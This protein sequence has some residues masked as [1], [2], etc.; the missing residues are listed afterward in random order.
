MRMTFDRAIARVAERT[1]KN[2]E[3]VKESTLQRRDQ[4]VDLYGIPFYASGDAGTPAKI[5]ISVSQDRIYFL[6]FQFKLIIRPFLTSVAGNGVGSATVDV[7]INNTSLTT[8]GSTITPNPHKHTTTVQPHTHNLTGGVTLTHTTSTDFDIFVD[9]VDVTPY[10][11]AQ[12]DEWIDGEGIYPGADVNMSYDL[13]KVASD[14]VAEGHK[15]RSDKL[16]AAGF[17]TIEIRSNG[18]FAVELHAYLKYSHVAR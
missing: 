7:A 9:G 5:Y 15:G 13:L 10:L 2:Y 3:Y 8:N 14:M 17:K 12:Y 6:R 11:I 1:A 18:P 4:V 16:L